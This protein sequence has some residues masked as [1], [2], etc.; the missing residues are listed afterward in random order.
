MVS[1]LSLVSSDARPSVRNAARGSEPCFHASTQAGEVK[2]A[3]AQ[4]GWRR[5][6]HAPLP[7]SPGQAF[8]SP[9]GDK[10][11]QGWQQERHPVWAGAACTWPGRWWVNLN[12]DAHCVAV[13]GSGGFR[14]LSNHRSPTAEGEAESFGGGTC[15]GSHHC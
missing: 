12:D 4:A 2:N 13:H 11:P 6:W 3:K 14:V 15:P 1:V 9:C 7:L 8:G 5:S 10:G